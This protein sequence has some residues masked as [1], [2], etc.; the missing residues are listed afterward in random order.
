MTTK[1]EL[2]KFAEEQYYGRGQNPRDIPLWEILL[3]EHANK[4]YIMENS[5]GEIV[6]SGFPDTGDRYSPGFYY[7]LDDAI[8]ALESNSCD[9]QEGCY[10]AALISCKFQ[11]LYPCC[12]VGARLYYVWD[13]QNK[14]FV[15]SEEPRIFKHVAF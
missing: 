14:K 12:T 10:E 15:Q 11:G 4:E 6:S 13:R 5:T 2:L 3:L 1:E 7:D 9:I 8:S